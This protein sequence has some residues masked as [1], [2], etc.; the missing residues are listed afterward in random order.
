M[1][2]THAHLEMLE[3]PDE[4]VERAFYGGVSYI[5]TVVDPT[6]N[7][8][9][10][11]ELAKRYDRVF[12]ICGIHP[13][14]ARLA[15]KETVRILR[16]LADHKKCIGVGEIGLDYFYM[17]SPEK[18]QIDIF[19]M[20]LEI[21]GEK[22]MPVVVHTRNAFEETLKIID[23]MGVAKTVIFHCFSEDA[24]EM[25]EVVNRGY[26]VSFSGILTYPKAQNVKN[27]AEKVP[28][29]KV[30]FETDSPFLSPQPVRGEK[31]QP[32]YVKY[33]YEEFATLRE[34]EI[35]SLKN[36]VRSNFLKAFD[37]NRLI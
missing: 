9:A 22:E 37:I 15:D 11:V 29:D 14:Q 30:L 28:L 3:N 12:F 20:Q 6:E 24:D 21:A 27:A 33:V 26:F 32:L 25:R 8:V 16:E 34:M 2:D 35:A 17:N 10:P 31:N 7:W 4:K 13:H 5:V 19:K 36:T 23:L 18:K 1:I